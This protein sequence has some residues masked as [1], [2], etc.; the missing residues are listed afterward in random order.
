[1][2]KKPAVFLDRD[3]VIN[4]YPGDF[5][6]VASAGEFHLLQ[7]A[8][9]A[10][11]RLKEAGFA[12]F[13]A[14]NQ[15]GVSKG[16]FSRKALDEITAL[17]LRELEARGAF[18][19]G[20]YYCTHLQ[21]DGC[22][23]RKPRG[24]MIEQAVRDSSA[25]GVEIDTAG[26][27]FVGDSVIDVQ[28]GR[29][30]GLTTVLVFSGRE[31][32]E[33]R[34]FWKT[35]PHYTARGVAEAAGLILEL[36]KRGEAKGAKK[37]IVIAYASAGAGH[38]KAA[39]A[40]FN[41]LKRHYPQY[42]V[43]K[44]D[45]LRM[46][47]AWFRFAY[48]YGYVLL[49]KY[50]PFLWSFI[51][52]LTALRRPLLPSAADPLRL[53]NH[54]ATAGFRA[55][56]LRESPWAVI[57]THFLCSEISAQ[58]KQ[59]GVIG[60]RIFTV[61]TDFGVH[62]LWK[63]EGTDLYFAASEHTR[64]ELFSLGVP[65]ERVS[66][67]GIPVAEEFID[68]GTRR[69]QVGRPKGE[70]TILVATGSFGIGPFERI[71]R[72]LFRDVRIIVVCACNRRLYRR[73]KTKNYPGVKVLGMI[74]NMYDVMAE[75]DLIITKPGGLTISESLIMEVVPVF[76]MAIPGQEEENARFIDRSRAGFYLRGTAGLR[77]LV[78][79]LKNDKKEITRLQDNIRRIKKIN[80]LKDICDAVCQSSPGTAG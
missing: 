61:I 8:A 75:A 30:A 5:Q 47:S 76:I 46:S 45:I 6:Y 3:G 1:M 57:N 52:T 24:G 39:E 18:I 37:K 72:S 55:Y 48:T 29:Q 25:S 12:V 16:I 51:F 53:L 7:G 78:L 40:L 65:P 2:M 56:L 80:V 23:C 38:R 43:L 71:I 74:D 36:K 70:F 54:I 42:E 26:S 66:V 63:D 33:N 60:S 79:R 49:I 28:T 64:A 10:V 69:T 44:V 73:L 17:M 21:E 19:D 68:Y 11:R 59:K 13:V 50:F 9:E 32:E 14:S 35:S 20:V 27:F 62:P 67:T 4:K 31:K 58:M 22:P 77:G 41:Y 34:R 15:A